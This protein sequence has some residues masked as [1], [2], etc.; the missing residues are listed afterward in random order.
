MS[1]SVTWNPAFREMA[2]KLVTA[3]AMGLAVMPICDAMADMAMG[4]SGRMPVLYDTS[5]MIGCR[6]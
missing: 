5:A 1:S 4:R 2:R 6:I 3:A